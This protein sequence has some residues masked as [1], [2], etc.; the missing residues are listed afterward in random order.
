MRAEKFVKRVVASGNAG[1]VYVPKKW[2]SRYVV[3]SLVGVEDYVLKEL[4]PHMEDVKGVYLYG[5]HARR[6][7]SPDSDINVF[8]VS[9]K[10]IS[11]QKKPGLNV[12]ILSEDEV[13]SFASASPVEYYCMVREAV[14]LVE[15]H[16]LLE[17]LRD[18]VLEE[19]H[20]KKF[21]E[22]AERSIDLSERLAAEGDH[23]AAIYSLILRLRGLYVI[24]TGGYT[25]KGF[26]GYLA[27]KGLDRKE[28]KRFYDVYRMKRDDAPVRV[29]VAPSDVNI[30]QD[31]TKKVLEEVVKYLS[32]EEVRD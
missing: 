23:A 16:G 21:L 25:H 17:R 6:E 5:S 13:D 30:L 26:E 4:A 18:F 1:G 12:E 3:V 11:Y 32:I 10:R 29:Q 14:P 19:G 7:A 27:E 20:V 31:V 22:D 28:Y 9:K 15:D 2:V 8:V 24:K